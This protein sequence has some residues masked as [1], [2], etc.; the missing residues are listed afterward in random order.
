M[1]DTG[2]LLISKQGRDCSPVSTW[3][4]KRPAPVAI[5]TFRGTDSFL[6]VV[7]KGTSSLHGKYPCSLTITNFKKYSARY[8][9]IQTYQNVEIILW[10]DISNRKYSTSCFPGNGVLLVFT[11]QNRFQ[12]MQK[13]P[14]EISGCLQIYRQWDQ[15][16][17]MQLVQLDVH[18]HT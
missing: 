16:L 10:R 3:V 1:L 12:E 18:W 15:F 14:K 4:E 17:H 11:I 2:C 5:P 13:I 6:Q 7:S 8:L 9:F